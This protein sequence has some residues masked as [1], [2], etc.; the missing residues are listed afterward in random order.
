MIN[1]SKMKLEDSKVL[2][3]LAGAIEDTMA[4]PTEKFNNVCKKESMESAIVKYSSILVD[5]IKKTY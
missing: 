3:Q 1:S 4:K 5:A 2:E